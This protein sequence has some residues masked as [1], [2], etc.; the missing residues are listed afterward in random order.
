MKTKRT[1][2]GALLAEERRRLI[3]DTLHRA[4]K[5]TVPKLA[6]Q[7]QVS[8]PTVR[9]DLTRLEKSGLLRRTHGGALPVEPARYEPPYSERERAHSE[10][11]RT[12]A[13]VAA[14]MIEPG[15]TVLLDAGTTPFEIALEIRTRRDLTVVTNSL[16]TAWTLMENPALEV[17]LLGGL[18][19][20]R[21]KATLGPLVVRQLEAMSFDK[22]FVG[23]SGIDAKAGLTVVDFDAAQVKAAMIRH[24]RESIIVADSSKV[25]QIAFARIAPISTVGLLITD[26]D[27]DS[28]C[29]R[30]LQDE[31]LEVRIA[32]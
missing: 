26:K 7:L 27:A 13:R 22:A 21:R 6:E 17:I 14:A 16:S 3:V 12:I 25:G 31:G 8:F 18:I 5:V 15:E 29:V 2:N 11:K 9:A 19:Q 1:E 23:V 32:E 10:Q 24:A 4:G 30:D 20:E 28:R